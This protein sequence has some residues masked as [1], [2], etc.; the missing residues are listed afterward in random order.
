[1]TVDPRWY[2]SFFDDDDWLAITH[3]RDPDGE[4]ARAEV[5]FVLERLGVEPGARILDVGC[6]HGRHSLELARR[7]F[8]VTGLDI[9]ERSLELARRHAAEAGVELELVQGDMLELPWR[10]DFDGAINMFTGFGYFPEE[11]EDERAAAS[12]AAA[13]RPGGRF[14]LDSINPIVLGSARFEPKRWDEL[15]DGRVVLEERS[16]DAVT[17]R[18]DAKWTVIQKDGSRRQLAFSVRAYTYPELAALLRRAG[19]EPLSVHGGWAGEDLTR[20]TWK[21][22]VTSEV[23]AAL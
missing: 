13:L 22:I 1:V 6:G 14:L 15:G 20:E 4:R 12:I 7:G 2:E 3:E 9:S 10:G 16:Y 17:G 18:N 8:R 11:A 5:D 23:P 21:L 19:F